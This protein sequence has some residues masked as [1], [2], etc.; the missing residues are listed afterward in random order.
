MQPNSILMTDNEGKR[1]GNIEAVMDYILS[2]TFKMCDKT[3]HKTRIN[4]P[5]LLECRK[6]LS[7]LIDVDPTMEVSKVETYME[8]EKI[9]L[10]AEVHLQRG[11]YHVIMIENKVEANLRK[12]QLKNNKKKFTNFYTNKAGC[13]QH[14]WL[15]CADSSI[16]EEM[17]QQCKEN[18]FRS[19]TL[20]ALSDYVASDVGNAIFDE[21]WRRTW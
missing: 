5:L 6:I 19:I 8:R 1:Q 7:K 12:D 3:N 2:W 14:F 11:D 10:I 4:M 16:T 13:I 17:K 18:G 21:F 9:D 20:D 15:I